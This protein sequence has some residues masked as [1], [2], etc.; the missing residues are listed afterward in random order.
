MVSRK[1][2]YGIIAAVIVLGVFAFLLFS[3]FRP[4]DLVGEAYGTIG[5]NTISIYR[6]GKVYLDLT[7]QPF[8]YQP[9]TWF[10]GSDAYVSNL[11]Y[12]INNQVNKQGSGKVLKLSTSN[13]DSV[14][15]DTCLSAA[16]S[17]AYYIMLPSVSYGGN[18]GCLFDGTSNYYKIQV[19]DDKSVKIE[20][21]PHV[22]CG[23]GIVAGTE[24]CDDGN[25][26]NDDA[27][28]NTC[29]T[30][31]PDLIISRVGFY[32]AYS[33]DIRTSTYAPGNANLDGTR[34]HPVV[35]IK[36]IGTSAVDIRNYNSDISFQIHVN[37]NKDGNQVLS[38]NSQIN[39]Q[40][41]VVLQD[42]GY[43]GVSPIIAPGQESYRSLTDIVLSTGNYCFANVQ[44]DA[45]DVIAESNETNNNFDSCLTVTSSASCTD[46]IQNQDETGVDCGGS[47]GA[48]VVANTSIN[49]VLTLYTNSTSVTNVTGGGLPPMKLVSTLVKICSGESPLTCVSDNEISF[50]GGN[51]YTIN[52]TA[53]ISPGGTISKVGTYPLSYSGGSSHETAICQGSSDCSKTIYFTY[54][55]LLKIA[56]I[57]IR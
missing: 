38:F 13:Y 23:D 26:V 19:L 21:L 16:S 4:G 46:S 56:A 6:G 3:Q 36:N 37:L 41:Q 45:I 11:Q 8:R 10:K 50:S 9:S 42:D 44:I 53:V 43:Y 15:R 31:Q 39:P 1:V 18:V 27:C 47:C 40:S 17:T 5:T 32:D 35:V 7:P 2:N 24:Q 52:G 12:N 54:N 14:G 28:S 57:G 20:F 49:V 25:T 22:V 48:C 30:Q 29:V 34:V 51:L 55:R 33:G